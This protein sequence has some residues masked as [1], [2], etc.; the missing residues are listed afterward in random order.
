VPLALTLLQAVCANPIALTSRGPGFTSLGCH[1]D[2]VNGARA[3]SAS[4]SFENG[5]TVDRCFALC[6]NFKYFGVEYGTEC[7][8][9]NTIDAG[10]TS[11]DAAEC[12]FPCGGDATQQ[13]GAGARINLYQNNAYTAPGPASS[14]Q[15]PYVG[16]FVDTPARVLPDKL[17][18]A[19]DMT[20]AKCAQNCEG[21]AFF[22]TQWSQECFCGNN[23]PTQTAPESEC[24]MPCAGDSSQ[25]CGAGMRLSVYKHAA[26]SPPEENDEPEAQPVTGAFAYHGCYS[27][28]A[29]RVLQGK[30]TV[31]HAMTPTLCATHCADYAYFG[32]EYGTECYC[33]TNLEAAST[34]QPEAECTMPCGGNSSLTCGGPVRLSVYKK[35]VSEEPKNLASIAEFQYRSC[36]E[37][38]VYGRVLTGPT[39][40]ADGM[41]VE[42]CAAFC[43]AYRYFGVEYSSECFCGDA[44]SGKE[45][46]AGECAMLCSGDK[47]QWCGGPN[48]LNLYGKADPATTTTASS[49]SSSIESATTIAS[50]T[51]TTATT[52]ESASEPA[53]TSS[54][55]SSTTSSVAPSTTTSTVAP[56]TSTAPAQPPIKLNVNLLNNAGFDGSLAGWIYTNSRINSGSTASLTNERVQSG[57][58]AFKF[59]YQNPN[60]LSCNNAYVKFIQTVSVDVGGQYE[61]AFWWQQTMNTA[62]CYVY[63]ESSNNPWNQDTAEWLQTRL[64]GQP[65]NSWQRFSKTFTVTS[66]TITI[67]FAAV[68]P[69][70]SFSMGANGRNTI[71]LD[72]ASLMRVA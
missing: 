1:S 27:D 39:T 19:N 54:T 60:C 33:G 68:C 6:S 59:Y 8:C 15:Y 20:I 22:G 12:S 40:A 69:N 37:D 18:G 11:V 43:S 4:A 49:T 52:T 67:G 66:P 44:L 57:T 7:Y 45:A 31:D 25:L 14:P 38:S 56:P 24:N 3:L 2:L 61:F 30:V 21:Y 16:C 53:P 58:T 64:Q 35:S 70:T 51:S 13:C 50:A 5:M 17:T 32:V 62:N 42:K 72:S 28:G 71:F 63:M 65:I 9:G 29:P 36:W 55:T 26:A 41:T 23:P 48:R 46:P 10:S 34:K 47:K